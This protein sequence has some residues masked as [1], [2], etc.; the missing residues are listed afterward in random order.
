MSVQKREIQ[1]TVEMLYNETVYP[2]KQKEM[3]SRMYPRL[4]HMGENCWQSIQV[5]G[6]KQHQN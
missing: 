5:K 3:R 1:D 2:R 6:T 4:G